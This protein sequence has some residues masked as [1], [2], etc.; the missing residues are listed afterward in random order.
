LETYD[1]LAIPSRWLET[2]PLVALEARAAGRPVAAARRGGLAEIVREPED[3]W[4]LTPDDVQ[5]WTALFATLAED[6]SIA[7]RLHGSKPV[8]QMR[9]VCDEMISL[10]DEIGDP[11][12]ADLKVRPADGGQRSHVGRTFRSANSRTRH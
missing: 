9:H 12:K 11:V 3:G 2:G 5:A 1:L 4:L 6:P 10:Y 8:R 7:R